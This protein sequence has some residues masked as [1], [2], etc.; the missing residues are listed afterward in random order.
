MLFKIKLSI[1]TAHNI[2]LF[3]V[4]TMSL[5]A[6]AANLKTEALSD[7]NTPV[8]VNGTQMLSEAK[9]EQAEANI[10]TLT[11]QIKYQKIEGGF[12]GFIANNGD[13][14]MPSGLK[15][16]Y[17]LNGL[18]VELKVEAIEGMVTTQQFGKLVKVLEIKVLDA[19]KVVTNDNTM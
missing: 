5:S 3:M 19:S 17:R 18:I 11:G 13:K 10:M 8:N 9:S 14:Y 1:K 2:I 12:Y 16:E 6:C 7:N 15:S 4:L